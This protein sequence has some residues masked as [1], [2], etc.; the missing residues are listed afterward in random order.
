MHNLL[1]LLF[2]CTGGY[3]GEYTG[4]YTGEYTGEYTGG[5]TGEYTGG[6][7]GEYTGEYTGGYTGLL[8]ACLQVHV[9]GRCGEF[10]LFKRN[11]L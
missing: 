8:P 9:H 11:F 6:Y 10:F 7:T 1:I 4:G 3:T 2:N 5:Y